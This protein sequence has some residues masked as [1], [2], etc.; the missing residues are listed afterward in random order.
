MKIHTSIKLPDDHWKHRRPSHADVAAAMRNTDSWVRVG[1]YATRKAAH[2]IAYLVRNGHI[3]AYASR[4][5]DA[6]TIT[7]AAG[8]HEVWGRYIGERVSRR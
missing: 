1:D 2:N 6:K 4:I 3:S 8:E 5:Y 7:N